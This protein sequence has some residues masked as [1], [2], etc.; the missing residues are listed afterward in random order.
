MQYMY[1]GKNVTNESFNDTDGNS[2]PANWAKLATRE[3]R[4]A[5]G[6]VENSDSLPPTLGIDVPQSV[7]MRQARLALHQIGL[8]E[9]ID[10]AIK[11]MGAEAVIEWE[12][13]PTVNRD[14]RIVAMIQY[15]YRMSTEDIDNLFRTATLL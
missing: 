13:T 12:Y 3:Q 4:D 6:I 14:N 10:A 15:A 7:A 8:L 1:N 2:Y 11:M 5:I 9:S